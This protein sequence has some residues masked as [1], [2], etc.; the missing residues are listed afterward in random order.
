MIGS[1]SSEIREMLSRVTTWP[2]SDRI[3]LARQIL[4]TVDAEP[5]IA[6]RGYSA[7]EVIALLQMPQPAPDDA[8]CQ[9]ILEEERLRK[10][11]S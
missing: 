10:Y 11:G 2:V 1:R 6:K 4:E 5:S 9:Q 3:V 8:T 7:E